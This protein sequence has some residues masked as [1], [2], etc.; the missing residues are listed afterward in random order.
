[1]AEGYF[2]DTHMKTILDKTI[3][4]NSGN[5]PIS[6]ILAYVLQVLRYHQ[7]NIPFPSFLDAEYNGSGAVEPLS[8]TNGGSVKI[9]EWMLLPDLEVAPPPRCNVVFPCD[10]SQYQDTLDFTKI[11]TRLI[12]RL[13]GSGALSGNSDAET[14]LLLP[15]EFNDGI[16]EHGRYYNRPQEIYMGVH[17]VST[18]IQAPEFAEEMN[19][20]YME[21]FYRSEYEKLQHYNSLVL[22]SRTFNM[23]PILGLPMLVLMKNGRHK[24][25]ILNE[26]SIMYSPDGQAATVYGI[27]RV[28]SYNLPITAHSGGY[29]FQHEFYAP[30][31]IGS[32]IY[33]NLIGRDYQDEEVKTTGEEEPVSDLSVLAHLFD[34][35]GISDEELKELKSGPYALRDAVDKLFGEYKQSVSQVEYARKYGRRVPIT[36]KQFLEIVMKCTLTEEG[37]MALGG[38][39]L[40]TNSISVVDG[41]SEEIGDRISESTEIAGCF[42]RERQA[43]LYAAYRRFKALGESPI[44]D[45]EYVPLTTDEEV[46]YEME[47]M[48]QQMH[49]AHR[50][51]A[52]M[53]NITEGL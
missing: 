46:E 8:I 1:M 47:S 32:Y 6:K 16:I 28:R 14:T 34:A 20:E 9:N 45:E 26:L 22:G 52:M 48:Y 42:C 2:N 39:T 5:Y 35:E 30:E 10:Y 50:M 7:V 29:W 38:Y 53:D 23:K 19:S 18:M 24:V 25:G 51:E 36:K 13:T 43:A 27:N 41:S 44:A 4:Q 17:Q 37:K 40:A 31:N 33:P 49:S 21:G 12:T 3:G 15:D 11:P